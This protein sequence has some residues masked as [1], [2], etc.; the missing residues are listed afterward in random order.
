MAVI[1]YSLDWVQQA[2]CQDHDL[3]ILP[4]ETNGMSKPRRKDIRAAI[5]I[6]LGCPVFK[7]CRDWS[8]AVDKISPWSGVVVAG[9]YYGSTSPY[10]REEQNKDLQ[11][12]I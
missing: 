2:A 12:V 10:R 5:D 1:N 4:S 8:R 9:Y 7:E 6:C 11:E 3:H